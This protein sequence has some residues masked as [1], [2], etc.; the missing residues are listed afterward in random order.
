MHGETLKLTN[1]KLTKHEICI[2]FLGNGNST[3]CTQT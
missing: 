1:V 2:I 3:D